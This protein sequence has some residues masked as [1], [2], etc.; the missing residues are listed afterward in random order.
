MRIT[1]DMS[2]I[3]KATPATIRVITIT[4]LVGNAAPL[5]NGSRLRARR[6]PMIPPDGVG[7][8]DLFGAHYRVPD[9]LHVNVSVTI[10]DRRSHNEK[11]PASGE[12][13]VEWVLSL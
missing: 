3:G 13:K 6:H 5:W 2:T 10:N 4:C 12:A 9:E 7:G 1:S 11:G 8:R